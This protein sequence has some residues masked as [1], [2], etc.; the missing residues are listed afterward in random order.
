MNPSGSDL[1]VVKYSPDLSELWTAQLESEEVE[2]GNAIVVAQDC[3][4]QTAAFVAGTTSTVLQP[5]LT[6][7]CV[8]AEFQWVETFAPVGD[9]IAATANA[10]SIS[11][12]RS[13]FVA[14]SLDSAF[15]GF[16]ASV[17]DTVDED[18]NCLGEGEHLGTVIQMDICDDPTGVDATFGV[19]SRFDLSLIH[20]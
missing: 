5:V 15:Y 9:E 6:A 1:F 13:I 10:I 4:G 2:R 19:S 7:K 11:P 18:G 3:D 20:I 14:G 16:I 12:N 17:S 8:D